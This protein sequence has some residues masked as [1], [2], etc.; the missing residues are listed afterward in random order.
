M[1][2]MSKK[3]RAA[4]RAKANRM[5]GKGDPGKK[6]DASSWTP[7]EPLNTTAK[8]GARPV[9]ARIYKLGGAVQGD[10]GPCRADRKPRATGGSVSDY[11]NRDGVAANAKLGKPHVGAYKAGGRTKRDMGGAAGVP[12]DRMNFNSGHKPSGLM[13]GHK[14]GGAVKSGTYLGGTR[15]TGGRI[16]RAEGGSTYN[17][18][19]VD[20]EIRKDKRIGGKEAR[21]IHR[22]LSKGYPDPNDR[23]MSL[24]GAASKS[25]MAK[26]MYKPPPPEDTEGLK[27]GGRAER[28][29]GG[30]A[31]K[32]K[33][34]INIHINT[35]QAQPN[36]MPMPPMGGPV[37][38]P[39]MPLPMPPPGGAP[40]MGLAGGPPPGGPPGMPPMPP[41]GMP[42]KS[43]G[44]TTGMVHMT[45]GAGSGLGRL[46]KTKVQENSRR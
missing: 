23:K 44:R 43:G 29:T 2:E 1:S 41:G 7:P 39:Q 36:A 17:R 45:A 4:M 12:V 42:R 18:E 40:P 37:K 5:G 46:E 13:F 31:K 8:T 28:A 35:P 3:A 20:K 24:D 14:K 34:N 32:G 9:R 26:G 21:M 19:A 30:R 6:V 27:R 25:A 16:A 33:T 10:R 22:V 15:P 11:I 38:P